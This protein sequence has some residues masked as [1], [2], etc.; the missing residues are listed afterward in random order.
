MNYGN[1]CFFRAFSS[2]CA[3]A[4]SFPTSFPLICRRR[5]SGKVSGI[6]TEVEIL[7]DEYGLP[8]IFAASITDAVFGQGYAEAADRLWQLELLRAAAGRIGEIAGE[9]GLKM[10]RLYRTLGLGGLAARNMPRSTRRRARRSMPSPP[11][12]T[13]TLSAIRTLPVEFRV[14]DLVFEPWRAWMRLPYFT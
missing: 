2:G 11:A 10:D 7:R 8:H 9:K 13:L 14:L 3:F 5:R 4:L 1:D 6:S 12:S